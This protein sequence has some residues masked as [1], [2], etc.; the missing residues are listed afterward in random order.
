V[1][2]Q[3]KKIAFD[4]DYDISQNAWRL[5]EREFLRR[6]QVSAHELGND[7]LRDSVMELRKQGEE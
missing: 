2:S 6:A 7:D 4:C 3:L 5:I 1:Q